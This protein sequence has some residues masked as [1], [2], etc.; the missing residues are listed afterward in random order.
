MLGSKLGLA[1]RLSVF[2]NE[3]SGSPIQNWRHVKDKVISD[4]ESKK[5]SLRN[6]VNEEDNRRVIACSGCESTDYLKWR[7]SSQV[8]Y[9]GIVEPKFKIV[10][11]FCPFKGNLKIRMKRQ[12]NGDSKYWLWECSRIRFK[13]NIRF[14]LTLWQ[15]NG[16][17]YS[18]PIAERFKSP[19]DVNFIQL[20]DYDKDQYIFPQLKG[21]SIIYRY[22]RVF[23]VPKTD[24]R[25]RIIRLVMYAPQEVKEVKK[26][27][28][29]ICINKTEAK[30]YSLVEW[31]PLISTLWDLFS[32]IGYAITGCHTVAQERAINL[33]L[34]VLTDVATAFT[35]GFASAPLAVLKTGLKVG[36]KFGLKAGLKAAANV[37]K[38]SVKRSI[39]KL[40]KRRFKI[41]LRKVAANVGKL[42]VR[43]TIIDPALFL[44]NVGKFS[45]KLLLKLKKTFFNA[46]KTGRAGIAKLIN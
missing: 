4:T 14:V 30:I 40:V 25:R 37:A 34:C 19:T 27:N 3:Y 43:E 22:N 12:Q 38:T 16:W 9:L 13:K 31:I 24:L 6:Y 5:L 17:R 39:A 7:N 36:L 42:I 15:K 23:A 21:Y 28:A 26:G 44:K 8:T 35:F 1:N 11:V 41:T 45:K 10:L 32:S 2:F 46:V 18:L 20:F 33:A 29:K